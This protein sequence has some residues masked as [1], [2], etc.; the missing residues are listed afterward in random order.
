MF[1]EVIFI[2]GFFRFSQRTGVNIGSE[3]VF[4]L[5]LQN[6]CGREIC[7]V[8]SHISHH[9]IWP[10]KIKSSGKPRIKDWCMSSLI[11][12]VLLWENTHAGARVF[13]RYTD[14]FCGKKI[15]ELLDQRI[16]VSAMNCTSLLDCL[17][18]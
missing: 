3:S 12:F 2:H 9:R 16:S 6:Q 17:T 15:V 11:H 4:G 10:N 14:L 8:G 7:M 18:S 5:S 1:P 13:W